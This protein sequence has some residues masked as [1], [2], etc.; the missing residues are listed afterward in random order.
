MVV[1]AGG[2]NFKGVLEGQELVRVR[3]WHGSGGEC[4]SE[5]LGMDYVG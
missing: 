2:Q 3:A 1:L 4:S 5:G